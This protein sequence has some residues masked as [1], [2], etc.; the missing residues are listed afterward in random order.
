MRGEGAGGVASATAAADVMRLRVAELGLSLD[1]R[2]SGLLLAAPPSHV[3]FVQPQTVRVGGPSAQC[4]DLVMH[5]R[6][7]PLPEIRRWQTPLCLSEARELWLDDAAGFVFWAPLRSPPQL[8][9]VSADFA[10]GE[11]S[12]QPTF[13]S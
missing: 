13:L 12:A 8:I 11:K 3:K 9:S 5:V 7:G 1:A 4:N 10:A 6:N 2:G